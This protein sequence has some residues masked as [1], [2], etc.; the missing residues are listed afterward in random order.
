MVCHK[1]KN[2][3]LKE[4]K[5]S[6][7]KIIKEGRKETESDGGVV[8]KGVMEELEKKSERAGDS[9]GIADSRL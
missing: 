5:R 7:A 9:Q 4:I 6:W 1:K 2:L 8:E 3:V